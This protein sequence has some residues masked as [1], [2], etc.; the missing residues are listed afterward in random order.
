MNQFLKTITCEIDE[1]GNQTISYGVDENGKPALRNKM[2]YP[3]TYDPFILYRFGEN[4][5]ANG[6]AYSDHLLGNKARNKEEAEEKYKKHNDLC[7]K[8]FGDQGQ[9][10]D[11]RDPEKIE[12]FLRDYFES[13]DLKLIFVVE[14]CNWSTGYPVWRF[15]YHD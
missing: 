1:D 9:Y 4:S 5:E 2:Q 12:A 14:Y 13:P 11:Q 6:T 15:D 10:W 8:H 3:Y 7:Q